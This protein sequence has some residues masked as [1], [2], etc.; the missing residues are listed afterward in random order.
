MKMYKRRSGLMWAISFIVLALV[1]LAV[2]FG[3]FETPTKRLVIIIILGLLA[4]ANLLKL[5]WFPFFGFLAIIAH[6]NKEPLGLESVWPVYIAA[7]LL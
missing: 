7:L 3:L 2:G 1:I 5:N 6:I 4:L